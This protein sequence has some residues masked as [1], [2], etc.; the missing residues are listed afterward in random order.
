LLDLGCSTGAISAPFIAAGWTVYGLDF[1]AA[2][3]I[4]ARSAGLQAVAGDVARGLPFAPATFD[5]VLAGEII[6]HLVDTDAF[7]HE[8]YRVLRPGGALILT[9]PNLA[10]L[11]NR[12]RLLLGIYPIWVDYRLGQGEGH[13]RAY[14]PRV[15][16]RQL[17]E[18]G[19]I[20][21]KHVG[22][23]VPFVPQRFLN[24]IQAPWLAR[25]GDWL[26]G[27]AMDIIVKARKREK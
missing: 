17:Q 12:L 27:L 18:H 1:T 13:V 19:L 22:N 11:E 25:T 10:S 16:K 4:M 2:P 21:E 20:V 7:L 14:T 3:L 9:T 24:D 15:L 26:P 8:I 5:A 6:E 23:F